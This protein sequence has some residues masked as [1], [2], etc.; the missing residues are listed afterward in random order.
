VI[1]WQLEIEMVPERKDRL[2]ESGNTT[3]AG[4]QKFKGGMDQG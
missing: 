3:N 2:P 4:K 1:L